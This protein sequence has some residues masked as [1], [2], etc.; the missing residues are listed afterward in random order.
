[1]RGGVVSENPVAQ[2]HQSSSGGC[3]GGIS[4]K[5]SNM[6]WRGRVGHLREEILPPERVWIEEEMVQQTQRWWSMKSD[7][8]L[9]NWREGIVLP[10]S[11]G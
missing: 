6:A 10:P 9:S 8:P 1:M 2:G 3:S 4:P 11:W 5:G 7:T